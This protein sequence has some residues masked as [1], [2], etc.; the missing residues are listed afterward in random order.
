MSPGHGLGLSIV[1]SIVEAHHGNI[2]VASQVNQGTT[3][4]VRLPR[5]RA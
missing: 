2:R 4:E 5:R 3:F 1:R